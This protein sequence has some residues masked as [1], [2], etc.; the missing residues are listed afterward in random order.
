MRDHPAR[1]GDRRVGQRL[2]DDR[3]LDAAALEGLRGFEHLVLELAL[4]HVLAQ[5]GKAERIDELL[6]ALLAESEFPMRRHG[7]RL[8]QR[9]A[10]DHVLALGRERSVRILPGVAAVEQQ[11][12]VAALGTDRLDDGGD[13]VES[14]DPPI[15]LGER[16]E[17]LVGEGMGKRAAGRDLVGVEQGA[18]GQVRRQPLRAADAEIDRRLAEIDRLELGMNIG[19]VDQRHIAERFESEQV[20]LA[21]P[22]LRESARPPATRAGDRRGRGG[23]LQ[24]VTPCHHC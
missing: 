19:D 23:Q 16:H 12:A 7:V 21:E 14:A 13:A 17:I 3:D 20:R 6:H 4:A 24:K 15:G 1:I 11:H 5:E 10:V 9:H 22:L 2:A 18:A 8:Q